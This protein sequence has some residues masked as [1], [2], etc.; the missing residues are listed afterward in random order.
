MSVVEAAII[1]TGIVCVVWPSLVLL[2][3]YADDTDNYIVMFIGGVFIL[4]WVYLV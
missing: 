3:Q 2:G 4:S 1:T